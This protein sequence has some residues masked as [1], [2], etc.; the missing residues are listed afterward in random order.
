[1]AQYPVFF[2][3]RNK[4]AGHV[5]R[6]AW[7]LAIVSSI[8]GVIFLSSLFVFRSFP[9]A[10][11]TQQRFAV[12]NDVAKAPYLLPQAR[13]LA[14]AAQADKKKTKHPQHPFSATA[15]KAKATKVVGEGRE[16]PL[17]IGYYVNWDDS[18][19]ASLRANMQSLDWVAPSW[20]F[21]QGPDL[22]LKIQVDDKALDLIRREKPGMA[23][24][25][26]IQNASGAKWDGPGL[27]RLLADPEKRKARI[28]GM[29]AFLEEHKLQGLVFDFEQV[30]DNAHNDYLA[31][32]GE[33]RSAFQPKGFVVS[34]AAPFDDPRW[35]YKAYA[36]VSDYVMLMGYDEHWAE[37]EPGPIA[38]QSWF[39][40]RLALRMRDL[41][42]AHTIVAVGNYGYDWTVGSKAP[43]EDLTFQEIMLAA[44]D[45]RATVDLDS[46]TLNPRFSYMEDGQTH[47]VWFMDAVTA[48]NHL[49]AADKYRPAGYAI[50]RL[51][52]EDP[53]LWQVLPRSY[54]ASPPASLETIVPTADVN[55]I[56]KGELLQVAADPKAGARTFKTDEQNATIVAENYTAMPASFVIRRFG[57]AP[58]KIALTFDDGPSPE[59]T[60]KI[61]EILKEKNVH[62]T[63]FIIG[64]NGAASPKLVQ[65]VLAEGHDLGNHTFTHPNIG[66][67]SDSVA[68]IEINATQRL[69]EA[70]TGRSTRLFRPPYFGDAEPSTAQEI[71]PL[72]VAER[73][74]YV[75]VGLKVD[76]DDWMKPTADEIVQR[77]VAQSTD[78][79]LEKRGQIVLLHDS[80]GDRTTTVEALPRIID[81]LR[82]RGFEFATVSEMA[83]WS[84]DRAMPPVPADEAASVFNRYMFY[85]LNMFQNALTTLFIAAI[86]LG[87]GRLVVLCGLAAYGNR[88]R[89]RRADP[90]YVDDLSVSVLIPAF[91]EAKVIA[92]SIRQI[93]ASSHRKLDVI[94]VDD[95]STDNT[96]DV[97]RGEFAD[98]P[99]VS[100]IQ[101][102]NGGKAHAI[103]LAL[104]QATGDIVVVLDADTQFEPLTISRLVRWFADPKVGAVA[105][106]AKVGNRINVLT[107]WQALEYITAQNLERRAL[108]TLDCITVVPG[109]VGAWR[110]EAITGLGGFPSNTLAEDQ[111]LTISVQRAG[112]KVLF[113]ADA[114]AWTEAPDTMGGLAK[115]RFRWAFGTLQCLWK[116]RAA[117]L[118]PRY[119]ALGLVALPQVWLFQIVLALISPLVDL[120]LLVQIVRTGV[121]YLQH[122]SQFNPENFM[123]TLT[124]YAVFMTVDLSA[125]LIAFV[126][127]KREDRS[128][129]WWLVLQRFGYRQVMYYVVAK[130]VVRA[131]QGRVVG[132]GKLERKATVR[133][134]EPRE[135]DVRPAPREAPAVSGTAAVQVP[136]DGL[137]GHTPAT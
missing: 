29:L 129:L 116:H 54:G 97:V 44:R 130:S 102:S 32:L 48:Y 127:E 7:A 86:A 55:F 33:V 82:A 124:Y 9:E 30:P 71:G 69:I 93:L 90:P 101:T 131:L 104:A 41:D 65:R 85:T 46:A 105:G 96:A 135:A 103:N 91:N 27:G 47:R 106:N 26:M 58:G 68:A 35:N 122:G 120:L 8:A 61:L 115:Q 128:L 10:T 39:S 123:I 63:F 99:R 45:A 110:R 111:D 64:E 108:A 53:S 74:G 52:S 18:S 14:Y 31:F 15:A 3:P 76:P 34:I 121:D 87:L 107:R 77:I 13:S 56:G 51:G 114:V 88:R 92:A 50:W 38:S 100:L 72:E 83:G 4:R 28:E 49:R 70:L 11:Q 109:A 6:I 67:V 60:P 133:A 132:W 21:L 125:A 37:G 36:K 94:V 5:S 78:P 43:A 12:L 40:T 113:D 20:L 112:Y 79:D 117:N 95:G 2:D 25:A 73:L 62:A 57:D 59:W 98:D 136:V 89:K 134:M 24:M 126:L 118:N 17:T 81:E 16:K 19:F 80:G 1:M 22:D 23:I 75:T 119:G 137:P 66:E 84:R 42:P